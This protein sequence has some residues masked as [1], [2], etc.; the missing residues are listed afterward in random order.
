MSESGNEKKLVYAEFG[1]GG[2]YTG[3]SGSGDGGGG[4]MEARV[5]RLESDVEN[6]RDNLAEV[7]QDVRELRGDVKGVSTKTD[8]HFRWTIGIVLG[9][10]ATLAATL[11]GMIAKGFGWI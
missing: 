11:A 7:R 3:G 8:T 1:S 5:A 6:I 9:T 4:D 10:G 2:G